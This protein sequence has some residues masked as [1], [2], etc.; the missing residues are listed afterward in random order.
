MLSR[1]FRVAEAEQ[2]V[3]AMRWLLFLDESGHDHKATPYEVR[4]GIAIHA[5]K[6]WPLVQAVQRLELDCF[7]APLTEDPETEDTAYVIHA[8]PLTDR[9]KR[10]ERKRSR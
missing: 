3:S 6:L 4:G 2:G 5:G 8:R 10:R 9:E 7:G 1:E